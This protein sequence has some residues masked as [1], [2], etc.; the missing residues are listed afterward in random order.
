MKKTLSI[1]ALFAVA[2][3][4]AQQ[5]DT[6]KKVMSETPIPIAAPH[7]Q[8]FSE[9]MHER[10]AKEGLKVYLSND[11]SQWLKATMVAQIWLRDNDN[12]PGST[13]FG[14]GQRETQDAGLRRL[15]FQL[16][17]HVSKY[18]FVYAQF[19]M[20]NFNYISP[21]K[22]DAFFHDAVAEYKVYK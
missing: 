2:I 9:K 3:S 21:R 11:S 19:G 17:G 18:M 5:A 6:M 7:Q 20:N 8:S 14:Y 1:A 22:Q 16:F 10:F 15:R 4:T 12:N 13:V